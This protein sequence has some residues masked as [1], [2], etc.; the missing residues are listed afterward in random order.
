M[1]QGTGLFAFR[2][3]AALAVLGA[4]AGCAPAERAQAPVCRVAVPAGAPAASLGG[5]GNPPML[6]GQAEIDATAACLAPA[7]DAALARAEDATIRATR[8]WRPMSRTYLASEHGMFLQVFANA[9]AAKDY[10]LA[11]RGGKLPQGAAILKRSFRVAADGTAAAGPVFV[12][13]RMAPGYDAST[14]D[15]RFAVTTPD[16]PRVGES[17]GRDADKVAYCAACHRAAR[18]QDHLF[19]VPPRFRA[20]D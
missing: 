5:L 8:I 7:L 20:A 12:M 1:G 19:F 6:L 9:A 16:G 11:E 2:A 13:E 4:L 18:V 15:W 10:A 14:N 3:V 17:G